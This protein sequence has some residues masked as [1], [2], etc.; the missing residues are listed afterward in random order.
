MSKTPT[1][2]DKL[3]ALFAGQKFPKAGK[4]KNIDPKNKGTKSQLNALVKLAQ[5]K[6]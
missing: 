4:Y 5:P 2:G 1:F 3:L 6:V